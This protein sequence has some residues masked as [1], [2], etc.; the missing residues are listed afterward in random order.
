MLSVMPSVYG[1]GFE[2]SM[3]ERRPTGLALY[4]L[5][6]RFFIFDFSFYARRP[7]REAPRPARR[8]RPDPVRDRPRETSH[9][10]AVPPSAAVEDARV[11]GLDVVLAVDDVPRLRLIRSAAALNVAD[12]SETGGRSV[13]IAE[14]VSRRV[15]AATKEEQRCHERS[16]ARAAEKSVSTAT[17]TRAHAS[18]LATESGAPRSA[19][20][21]R[22]WHTEPRSTDS[23]IGLPR[24]RNFIELS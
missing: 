16:Q 8:S 10:P 14:A 24:R 13:P 18:R 7:S 23:P 9:K 2:K 3:C 11:E 17:N 15:A 1:V 12:A 4:N 20:R 5:L 19:H 21:P 22:S 6:T